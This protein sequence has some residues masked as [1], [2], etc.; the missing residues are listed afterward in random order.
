MKHSEW[1]KT[2]ISKT[3]KQRRFDTIDKLCHYQLSHPTRKIKVLDV[4]C[5]EGKDILSFIPKN[6]NIELYGL[7][8]KE[9][10]MINKDVNFIIGDASNMDYPDDF[11]D[12]IVSVGTLEHV[13]PIEKLCD[14]IKEINRVSKE[15]YIMVPAITTPYEPH[16]HQ[17][18]WGLRRH[19][20]HHP[21][22]MFFDDLTWLKFEGFSHAFVTRFWYIPGFISNLIIYKN[23]EATKKATVEYKLWQ[24]KKY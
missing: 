21:W 4:G 17:F 6:P 3:F 2:G 18:F 24:K 8:I 1:L 7:D 20:K 9:Y 11:F 10:D 12:I 13:Q 22:L 5:A 23:T 14:A 15:F 19:R 16:A